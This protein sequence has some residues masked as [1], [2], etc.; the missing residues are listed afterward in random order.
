[1]NTNSGQGNNGALG[2]FEEDWNFKKGTLMGGR[3]TNSRR[4]LPSGGVGFMDAAKCWT[5]VF[6]LFALLYAGALSERA[7]AADRQL[8]QAEVESWFDSSLVDGLGNPLR[9]RPNVQVTEFID[10]AETFQA[11]NRQLKVTG[12][13]SY[14]YLLN[15]WIDDSF[16][17][18]GV[19][20][21]ATLFQRLKDASDSGVQIRGIF[22]QQVLTPP[23]KVLADINSLPYGSAILDHKTRS[24]GSHH[25]KILIIYDGNNDQ[26]VAFC[27]GIDFNRDRLYPEHVNGSIQKGSPDHDVHCMFRGPAAW[28]LLTIFKKRWFDHPSV[29]TLPTS[30]I[31]KQGLLGYILPRNIESTYNL[32]HKQWAQVGHT[33]PPPGPPTPTDWYNFAPHGEQTARAI[34]LHAIAQA[35]KYI[36]FEDQYMVSQEASRALAVALAKNP[37]LQLIIL[38]P[39]WPITDPEPLLKEHRDQFLA[40]LK[41]VAPNR[42]RVYV[43]DTPTGEHT[44]VHSKT[45]IFD[46]EFAIIG[47]AN[48]NS[49]SWTYDSEVVAGICDPGDGVNQRMPHRLRVRL[50]SEHLNASPDTLDDWS[51]ALALWPSAPPGNHRRRYIDSVGFRVRRPPKLQ[52]Y[53]DGFWN[54]EVDPDA[55][56]VP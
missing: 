27:G 15:W 2:S 32:T 45:W 40:P 29:A 1:M 14:I 20:P 11:M 7:S 6:S 21:N 12:K 30:P 49:R 5:F 51:A 34:I 26:L 53:L 50:W 23:K 47:S 8:S 28:D 54:R 44:Y 33:Y 42:V 56:P 17:L 22:W 39:D 16:P 48:C 3:G 35:K 4:L 19:D 25:Q 36:Y 37:N 31:N 24:F 9:V 10:G 18:V 41:S 43:L 46:D 38:I 13:K 55:G 52:Q